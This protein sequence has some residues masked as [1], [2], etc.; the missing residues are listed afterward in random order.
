MKALLASSSHFIDL[1]FLETTVLDCSFLDCEVS[2]GV[3]YA[4]II[5]SF[6]IHFQYKIKIP[7][8]NLSV[9]YLIKSKIK[10][11]N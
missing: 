3:Q 10:K 9:D 2:F 11:Q 1:M 5:S 8:R 6:H 4:F 7:I